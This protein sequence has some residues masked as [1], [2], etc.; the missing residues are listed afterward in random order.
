MN[1]TV[2][3]AR[4]NNASGGLLKPNPYAEVIIINK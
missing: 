2:D 4:L 1:L 3:S